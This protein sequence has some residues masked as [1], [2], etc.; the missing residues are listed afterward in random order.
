MSFNCHY[1][2]DAS[3]YFSY[4]FKIRGIQPAQIAP[5]AIATPYGKV[6]RLPSL[7]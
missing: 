3:L 7:E 5:K 2:P 4:T 1:L 6:E